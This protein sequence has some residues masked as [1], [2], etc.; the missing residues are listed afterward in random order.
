MIRRAN[1]HSS[2]EDNQWT[3]PVK[4]SFAEF[5]LLIRQKALEIMREKTHVELA[6]DLFKSGTYIGSGETDHLLSC[7]ISINISI[8]SFR[9]IFEEPMNLPPVIISL[10]HPLVAK[11]LASEKLLNRTA[12]IIRDFCL[13]HR[14]ISNTLVRQHYIILRNLEELLEGCEEIK[15][16]TQHMLDQARFQIPR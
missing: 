6:Y 10:Y 5:N 15:L 4:L 3:E 12:Q 11:L 16:C 13:T 2:N 9:K 8:C 14:T 7:L 1:D